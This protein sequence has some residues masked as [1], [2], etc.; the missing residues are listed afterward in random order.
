[1]LGQPGP[2]VLPAD[3]QPRI[4]SERLT[5]DFGAGVTGPI[6]ILVDTPGGAQRLENLSM[7][8]DL[9]KKLQADP[10][11]ARVFS[12]TSAVPFEIPLL[13]YVQI[14]SKG[15][16]GVDPRLRSFVAGMA[17]WDRGA[18]L[19]R[20]TVISKSLPQSRASEDLIA[21]IRNEYVFSSGL[22]T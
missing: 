7:V 19:S 12:L 1:R 10:D 18:T 8:S 20:I 17:N 3:E 11:V 22:D 14:Y 5:A 2:S 9:T 16:P 21:R 13:G 6:E 15:L 4:A